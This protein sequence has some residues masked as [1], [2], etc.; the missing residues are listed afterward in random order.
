V[1]KENYQS[2][3]YKYWQEKYKDRQ[4]KER[5][6]CGAAVRIHKLAEKYKDGHAHSACP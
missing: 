5:G 2:S 6:G 3:G 4:S 1:E